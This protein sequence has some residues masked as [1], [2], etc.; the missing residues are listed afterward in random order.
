M[1]ARKESYQQSQS[2]TGCGTR[3][4]TGRSLRHDFTINAWPLP[5]NTRERFGQLI[6]PSTGCR[7]CT[8]VAYAPWGTGSNL[9]RR[10]AAHD[11]GH[12]FCLAAGFFIELRYAGEAIAAKTHRDHRCRGITDELNKIILS[13]VPL[14]DSVAVQTGL[15]AIIFPEFRELG[16]ENM[17]GQCIKTTSSTSPC[18]G[19]PE[20]CVND[21]WLRWGHDINKFVFSRVTVDLPRT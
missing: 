4:P 20:W 13:P 3:Y 5:L 1:G 9:Q 6:D 21:L 16:V 19:Q 15:L 2:Q 11:A 10:S 12:T 8:T 7:T 18:T 14:P 17:E